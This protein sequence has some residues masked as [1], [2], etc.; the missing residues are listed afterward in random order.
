MVNV[1]LTQQGDIRNIGEHALLRSEIDFLNGVFKDVRVTVL[2]LY[3]ERIRKV[4]PTIETYPPLIDLQ[5]RGK[6]KLPLIL[7]PFLLCFQTMLACISLFLMKINLKPIYRPKVV[8]KFKHADL[9]ISGGTHAFMEGSMFQRGQ[10]IIA[11]T[12]NLFML[13]WG[14]YEVFIVKKVLRKPFMTFPQSMGPF[15]SWIGKLAIKYILDNADAILLREDYSLSLLEGVKGKAPI[16]V[17]ADM[18]FL[19]KGSSMS[20]RILPKPVI[21]VSP[22]FPHSFSQKQQEDYVI[23]HSQ[24][25]DCMIEKHDVNVVF[26]PS[27]IGQ[28]ETEKRESAKDDLEVC[29]MILQSMANKRK[30]EIACATTADEFES[31][32]EQLDLLITTRM[33]PSILAAIKYV[34][35][36]TIIY[37]HK[38]TG[39]LKKLGVEDT[40]IDINEVTF[41]KLRSRV[42]YIWNERMRIRHTLTLKIPAI[43]KETATTVKRVISM[44]LYDAKNS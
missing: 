11:K 23:A 26:L 27:V 32:V 36:A 28:G 33:H 40:A 5:T 18:A 37:E 30:S 2:T 8:E 1:I 22:C 6:N 10:T 17:A 16:Y 44:C 43:Q 21:G 3:P 7:Y 9:V 25:L 24:L 29:R 41:A 15:K 38:Q 4:E 13:F 39:L 12:I 42:E 34:P 20:R 14:A 31:L 19:F 35:F